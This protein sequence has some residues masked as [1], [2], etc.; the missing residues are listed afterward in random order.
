MG[1]KIRCGD[2][3]AAKVSNACEEDWVRNAGRTFRGR[4]GKAAALG[5][6]DPFLGEVF[7]V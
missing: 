4:G 6:S 5:A 7:L 1:G 2:W 3:Q